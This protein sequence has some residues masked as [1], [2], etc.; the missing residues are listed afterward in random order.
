MSTRRQ[1]KS[2]TGLIRPTVAI[3]ILSLFLA[4]CGGGGGG[5]STIVDSGNGGNTGAD[6]GNGGNT[7]GNTGGGTSGGGT[8]PS[9]NTSTSPGSNLVGS[10]AM[11]AGGNVV[12][13]GRVIESEENKNKTFPKEDA[14]FVNTFAGYFVHGKPTVPA[15]RP[16][17]GEATWDGNYEGFYQTRDENTQWSDETADTG[18]ATVTIDLDNTPDLVTVALTSDNMNAKTF[19]GGDASGADTYNFGADRT[20]AT[21][22]KTDRSTT[23]YKKVVG[24]VFGSNAQWVGGAYEFN[25]ETSSDRIQGAGWFGGAQA[26]A[27]PFDNAEAEDPTHISVDWGAWAMRPDGFSVNHA[28]GKFG[29]EDTHACSNCEGGYFINGTLTQPQNMPT[30]EVTWTGTYEGQYHTGTGDWSNA[31]DLAPDSGTVKLVANLGVE[32]PTVAVTLTTTSNTGTMPLYDGS[33]RADTVMVTGRDIVENQFLVFAPSDGLQVEG[34]FF[35]PKAERAV[36]VYEFGLSRDS[37]IP[38]AGFGVFSGDR[39]TD[40]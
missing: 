11:A 13:Y 12:D 4:S 3:A 32:T 2:I 37:T 35:G 23:P 40:E 9:G 26:G 18:T 34:G 22:Q 38:I 5:N 16:T 33:A 21:F 36:G 39:P 17:T 6:N 14:F 31:P 7:G 29:V 15:N 20:G 27:A 1:K 25:D 24:A 8:S 19:P 10:G 28:K 30:T